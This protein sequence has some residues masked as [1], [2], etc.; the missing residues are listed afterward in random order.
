MSEN[1]FVDYIRIFCRSGKGGK[2]SAH[3]RTEKFIAKGGPD[4]GDGG[5]GGH[6]ILKGNS[7]LMDLAA[8]AVQETY[9]CRSCR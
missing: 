8:S 9:F 6:V 1:N 7:Q 5:Q 2:G 3:L 4:G